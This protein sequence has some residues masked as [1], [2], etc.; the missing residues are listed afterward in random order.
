MKTTKFDPTTL[1]ARFAELSTQR[2]T[3]VAAAAPLREKRD[4]LVNKARE[5][6]KAINAEIR[7]A[8]AGLFELDQ[9]RAMI[10]RALGGKT[11]DPD[12]VTVN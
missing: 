11:S 5:D 3:I 1:R 12:A 8:E 7:K 4:A 6:E 9:E 2:E 10:S